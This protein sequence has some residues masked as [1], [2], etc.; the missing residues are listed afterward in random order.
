VARDRIQIPELAPG[1]RFDLEFAAQRA[2]NFPQ[3]IAEMV[4]F[5]VPGLVQSVGYIGNTGRV[6]FSNG[7]K[8]LIKHLADDSRFR[9][10]PDDDDLRATVHNAHGGFVLN[11][12]AQF[13]IPSQK[14]YGFVLTI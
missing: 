11:A 7:Y 8:H 13:A 2:G 10:I 14:L 12:L 5:A 1:A 3:N 4:Q 9:I 6:A